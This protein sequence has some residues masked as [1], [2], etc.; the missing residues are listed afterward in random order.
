MD[1]SQLKTDEVV[2]AVQCPRLGL[3]LKGPLR[4]RVE[5]VETRITPETLDTSSP[6]LE[7]EAAALYHLRGLSNK[8]LGLAGV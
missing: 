3:R 2:L 8:S 5:E 4:K 7:D 1:L 6:C